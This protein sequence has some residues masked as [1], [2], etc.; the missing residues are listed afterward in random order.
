MNRLSECGVHGG[1]MIYEECM[2]YLMNPIRCL[3]ETSGYL[4][5]LDF[6]SEYRGG[7]ELLG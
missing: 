1:D 7:N 4:F 2:V 6:L 5:L 3:V